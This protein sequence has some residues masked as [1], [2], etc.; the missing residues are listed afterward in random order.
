M[1]LAVGD[2]EPMSGIIPPTRLLAPVTVLSKVLGL[3]IQPSTSLG[4]FVIS[5]AGA[6]AHSRMICGKVDGKFINSV[7]PGTTRLVPTLFT[8]TTGF[9]MASAFLLVVGSAV[10]CLASPVL[11]EASSGDLSIALPTLSPMVETAPPTSRHGWMYWSLKV[12]TTT[13]GM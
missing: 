13:S 11:P 3:V 9:P 4:T 5:D 7:T 12:L 1:L 10:D 2:I 8:K 6:V